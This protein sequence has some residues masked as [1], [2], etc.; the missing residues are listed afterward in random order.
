MCKKIKTI[1]KIQAIIFRSVSI[2]NDIKRYQKQVQRT[3]P[4]CNIK[5]KHTN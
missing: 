1:F 3:I 4:Y 5:K 2:Y